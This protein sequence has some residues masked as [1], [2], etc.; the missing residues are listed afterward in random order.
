M[1]SLFPDDPKSH[2]FGSV[3]DGVFDGQIRTS[4]EGLFYVE[5]IQR[6]SD[7]DVGNTSAHSVIYHESH[8]KD[9]YKH[10]KSG[11]E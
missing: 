8:I 1:L 3:R 10:K 2:C 5:R 6:Y 4:R 7:V 9:P 11:K